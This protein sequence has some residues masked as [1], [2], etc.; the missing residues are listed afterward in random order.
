MLAIDD[1]ESYDDAND[2]LFILYL[3]EK[4]IHDEY[5]PTLEHF[6]TAYMPLESCELKKLVNRFDI[7]KGCIQNIFNY[8]FV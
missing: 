6:N 2:L 1:Y 3:F 5:T 7:M 4:V 8:Y